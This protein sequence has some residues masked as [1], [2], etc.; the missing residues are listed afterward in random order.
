MR[1]GKATTIICH[2]LQF[3]KAKFSVLLSRYLVAAITS[4]SVSLCFLHMY[5]D[6]SL[7]QLIAKCCL[8]LQ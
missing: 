2:S 5:N 3:G 1:L 8:I 6:F 4:D 7:L